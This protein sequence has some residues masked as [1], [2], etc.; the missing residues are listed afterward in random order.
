MCR[1]LPLCLLL[2]FGF[3]QTVMAEPAESTAFETQSLSESEAAEL[4]QLPNGMSDDAAASYTEQMDDIYS[5]GDVDTGFAIIEDPDLVLGYHEAS[6]MYTYTLPDGSR[7]AVSVPNTAVTT[8]TVRLVLPEN[9]LLQSCTRDGVD[10][11]ELSKELTEPGSYTLQLLETGMASYD[12][13]NPTELQNTN[14]YSFTLHF[15]IC[16][17]VNNSLELVQAPEGFQISAVSRN[18]KRSEEARSYYFLP[19]DGSYVFEF[20]SLENDIPY[21]LR[22]T[23]DETPPRLSFE[24]LGEDRI[25]KSPLAVSSAEPCTVEVQHNGENYHL[26]QDKQQH[27]Q[28]SLTGNGVFRLTAEDAAGNTR[29]YVVLLKS[30]SRLPSLLRGIFFLG[31]AALLSVVMIG[32]KML[33]GNGLL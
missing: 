2:S 15:R 13:D 21:E 25:A 4:Q 22:F 26:S 31:L 11:Y 17:N 32:K 8:Q 23:L 33:V 18:G 16:E 1:F 3:S 10:Q 12:A 9:M 7:F 28:G 20:R 29:S 6:G 30:S 27:I 24:G 19:G 5:T 14:N